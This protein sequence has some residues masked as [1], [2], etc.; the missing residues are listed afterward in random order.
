VI[1]G[2]AGK[3]RLKSPR[4]LD[5]RPTSDRV[6]EALFNILGEH[7]ADSCFLD[8]FAGTGNVGIEALSR[9]AHSV[10]FVE[11]NHQNIRYIKKNLEIT[12]L[13]ARARLIRLDTE[14]ALIMLGKEGRRFNLIFLD[15]PYLQ[16]FEASAL[17]QIDYQ[18]LLRPDGIIVIESSKKDRLPGNPGRLE[19]FRQKRYG[20]TMLTFYRQNK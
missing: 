9:G 12:S 19:M 7:V 20:D 16:N 4:G 1:S 10:V 2:T 15:P 5:V 14:K 17:A 18:E 13:G 6:K 3:R 8:L 11:N